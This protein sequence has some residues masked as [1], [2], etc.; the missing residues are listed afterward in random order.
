[1]DVFFVLFQ[2]FVIEGRKKNFFVFLMKTEKR[3]ILEKKT[4]NQC[5]YNFSTSP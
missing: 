4:G 2:T 3:I 5:C 1:M